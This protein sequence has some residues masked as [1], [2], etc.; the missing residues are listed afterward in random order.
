MKLVAQEEE[1]KG[2]GGGAGLKGFNYSPRHL[3]IALK[4]GPAQA[5][6]GKEQGG[7]NEGFGTTS[8]YELSL[9]GEKGEGR[10]PWSRRVRR[11]SRRN[12]II[13]GLI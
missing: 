8:N 6:S 5:F 7:R 12:G 11:G 2:R 13:G 3:T 10:G 9:G 1:E 4:I